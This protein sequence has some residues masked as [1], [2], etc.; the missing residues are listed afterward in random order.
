MNLNIQTKNVI[1]IFYFSKMSTTNSNSNIEIELEV[2]TLNIPDNAPLV[3]SEASQSTSAPVKTKEYHYKNKNGKDVKVVRKYTVKNDK[4]FR[5]IANKEKMTK[6]IE[7]HKD[8]Y[9]EIKSC[10]RITTLKKD[11]KNDLELELSQTGAITL[12]KHVN[13]WK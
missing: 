6:Y 4:T 7:E 11:I 5:S 10:H 12:L 2:E 13:L 8:K 1:L 3:L 9:A